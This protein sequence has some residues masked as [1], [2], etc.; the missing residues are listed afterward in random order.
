MICRYH[1]KYT[2]DCKQCLMDPGL[3]K[4]REGRALAA[5]E[6]LRRN[7]KPSSRALFVS[8]QSYEIPVPNRNS[9]KVA[10]FDDPKIPN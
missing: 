6:V 4:I 1:R 2:K 9:P 10:S 3:E 5:D 7:H 8:A